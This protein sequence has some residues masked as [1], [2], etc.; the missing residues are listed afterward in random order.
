M[1]AYVEVCD[2]P[3]TIAA[4]SSVMQVPSV[5]P[6]PD[7]QEYRMFVPSLVA[8]NGTLAE[9]AVM[10]GNPDHS[11]SWVISASGVLMIAESNDAKLCPAVLIATRRNL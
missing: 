11:L 7:F 9:S 10:H 6:P 2:R 3:R 4:Q 8:W 5:P 1:L